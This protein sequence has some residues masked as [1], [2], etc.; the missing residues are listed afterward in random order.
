MKKYIAI[1]ITSTILFASCS[2]NT[3]DG[4]EKLVAKGDRV[5]GGYLRISESDNYQTLYPSAITD[6]ISAFI[7][8]QIND[9]LV[10]LNTATLKVEPSLAEKWDV[11]ASGTKYTFHLKKGSMFQNDEC[12]AGGKGREIKASDVKYSFELICSKGPDNQTFVSTFK[13][14]ILGANK[15][16]DEG[17]GNVEGIKIIDDYTLEISLVRPSI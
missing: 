1:V 17:K 6:V 12:Y 14:R 8:T 13:D 3:H 4:K 11:D 10:K 15:A 9:G 5:Y 16:Y 7:A 2:N